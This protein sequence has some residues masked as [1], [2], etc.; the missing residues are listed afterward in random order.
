M[1]PT[2]SERT[3]ECFA[4]IRKAADLLPKDANAQ[5]KAA[6]L[7]LRAGRFDDAK[8]R[9]DQALAAARK[10]L[11][12][13]L[14]RGNALA[15]FKDLDGA[16]AEYEQAIAVDPSRADA[17]INMGTIRF[18]QGK[19]AEA[20]ESFKQVV[21]ANGR[22]VRARLALANFYW[23][24]AVCPRCRA[25]RSR[26]LLKSTSRT[27]RA[28]RALGSYY[29]ATG[30]FTAGRALLQGSRGGRRHR[31]VDDHAG[32][33]LCGRQQTHRGAHLV[34]GYCEATGW[35]CGSDGSARRARRMENRSAD[36]KTQIHEVL[37]NIRGTIWRRF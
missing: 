21:A 7:F 18:A 20:E 28:N 22:S 17:Y 37:A 27:S 10:N 19:T 33:I 16:I 32:A 35:L 2:F 30:R 1:T 13:Q 3:C 11:D 36:A 23:R 24:A 31:R 25:R 4:G 34:A 26:M 14:V 5:L 8:A 6:T 15:G 9:A 29:V 12:A